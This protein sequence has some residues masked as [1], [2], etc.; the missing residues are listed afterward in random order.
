MEIPKFEKYGGKSDPQMH[1]CAFNSLCIYFFHHDALME[2]LFPQSLKDTKLEWYCSLPDNSI[3]SFD[4]L[5]N[6]FL[7][8]FQA[9]IRLKMTFS[10]LVQCKQGDNEKITDFIVRYQVLFSK[11]SYLLPDSNVQKVFI[12]NLQSPW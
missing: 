12:G 6:Q 3:F 7:R 11:I 2:N 5:V 8:Q 4:Q 10:D 9:N 1:V